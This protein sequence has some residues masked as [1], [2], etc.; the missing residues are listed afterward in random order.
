MVFVIMMFIINK[1]VIGK[2]ISVDIM[3]MLKIDL[4]RDLFLRKFIFVVFNMGFM[5][6][7]GI[8]NN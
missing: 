5:K 1:I 8:G 7:I 6:E 3:V 4:L 2:I